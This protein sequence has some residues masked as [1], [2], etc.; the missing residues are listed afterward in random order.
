MTNEAKQGFH[1][2][3]DGTY[4]VQAIFKK[5]GPNHSRKSLED[6]MTFFKEVE[7]S[8]YYDGRARAYRQALAEI[9]ILEAVS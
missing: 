3:I 7:G 8:P 6:M 1:G 5:F 2:F 9:D 4:E